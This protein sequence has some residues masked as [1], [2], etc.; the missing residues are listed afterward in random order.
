MQQRSEKLNPFQAATSSVADVDH[1]WKVVV[2][3]GLLMF[4]NLGPVLYYTAGVFTKAISVDTG[5]PRGTIASA[6]LPANIAITILYPLVG[7]AVE[8]FGGR[9]IS[10]LSSVAFGAAL[11]ALGH[12]AVSP[13]SF[14]VLMF[15]ASLAAFGLTPLPTVQMISGW[16]DK[17]RG[18]A[19]SISLALGGVGTALLPPIAAALILKLGWRNAYMALGVIVVV[20]GLIATVFLVRD[21][22]RKT[23]SPVVRRGEGGDVTLGSAILTLNFWKLSLAF[24]AISIAIS[25]G[26]NSLPMMLTDSGVSS[27]KSAFAMSVMGGAMILGRIALARFLDHV[28][29]TLLTAAIFLAPALAFVSLLS[30]L[31]VA[32]SSFLAAALLGIGLGAEVDALGYISSRIFGVA[33]LGR[34]FGFLMIAF[35]VG[36][37]LGPLVFGRIFD[38]TGSYV[39][40]LWVA[41]AAALIAALTMVSFKKRDLRFGVH[42]HDLG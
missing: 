15:I 19:L 33:H 13:A 20:L 36:L 9:R 21:P 26:A 11:A 2:G 17:K 42:N 3:S 6:G 7:L 24:L 32:V 1:A 25:G 4:I 22:P 12:F 14:A 38:S 39:G 8:A 31:P 40:A 35:T 37:G 23:L 29:A 16:F 10:L 5:W 30:P 34:I 41:L 27:Q 18:M 28:F